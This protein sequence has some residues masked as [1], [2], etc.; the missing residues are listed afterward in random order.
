MGILDNL[1]KTALDKI[2]DTT[3]KTIGNSLGKKLSNSIGSTIGNSIGNKIENALGGVSSKINSSRESFTQPSAAAPQKE[4]S[5]NS[6]NIDE[7]S[8]NID[9]QSANIDKKF[10]QI[11]ASEFSNLTVVKNA[12]PESM[13]VPAL[14]PCKAYS[15][16]LLRNGK[17]VA[18]IML[19][20]H[21]RDRNAAF[22]NA[23]K[24]ALD[25]KIAF[26]NFYT[27]FPNE[28]GYVVSRIKNAL[29]LFM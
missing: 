7:K 28:H 11:L 27:H 20:P 1:K 14:Q 22:L 19:T 25:S 29:L 18:A 10:D 3:G 5:G 23:K 4:H 24:S 13:G 16:G 9:H 2:V 21:N 17:I 12:S 6:V 26:L 15:Y 8:A